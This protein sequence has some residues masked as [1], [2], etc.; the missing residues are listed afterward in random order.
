MFFRD[1]YLAQ[2]P[3]WGPGNP[4]GSEGATI[5]VDGLI[6]LE[7]SLGGRGGKSTYLAKRDCYIL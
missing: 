2:D 4:F 1:Q 5:T 7:T 3:I 6:G